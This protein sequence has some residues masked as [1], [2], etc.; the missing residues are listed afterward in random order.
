MDGLSKVKGEQVEWLAE[1]LATRLGVKTLILN[2]GHNG[3][4]D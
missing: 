2:L 3:L 1:L 4:E